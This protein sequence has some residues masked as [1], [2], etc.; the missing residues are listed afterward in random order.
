MNRTNI[1]KNQPSMVNG[2]YG[3]TRALMKK[4]TGEVAA[5]TP[6]A[7]QSNTRLFLGA[8][9][10]NAIAPK[11]RVMN[12]GIQSSSKSSSMITLRL[13]NIVEGFRRHDSNT[14]RQKAHFYRTGVSLNRAA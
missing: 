12:T 14:C 5:N 8:I 11:K 9:K 10:T 2:T 4:A 1:T 7:C 3:D 13:F 6:A